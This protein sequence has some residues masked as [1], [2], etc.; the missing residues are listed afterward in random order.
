MQEE[1]IHAVYLPDITDTSHELLNTTIKGWEELI[2]TGNIA[3][4]FN[5][6]KNNTGS[7]APLQTK[8][9][10][11]AKT[12][13]PNDESAQTGETY[14]FESIKK[15]FRNVS[16]LT[17]LAEIELQRSNQKKARNYLIAALAIEPQNPAAKALW[18]KMH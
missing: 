9:G 18:E 16:A 1:G 6:F 17:R 7:A 2:E 12:I 13:D 15:D 4:S 3:D 14:L 11:Q 5:M 10:N 8:F